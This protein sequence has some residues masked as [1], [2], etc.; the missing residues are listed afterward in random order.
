MSNRYNDLE[1]QEGIVEGNSIVSGTLKMATI[2]VLTA[3]TG[4]V[5][6]LVCGSAA[7]AGVAAKEISSHKKRERERNGK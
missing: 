6:A 4:G 3:A 5:A 7:I 2:G 1:E